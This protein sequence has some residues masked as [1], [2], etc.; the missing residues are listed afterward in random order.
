M[1]DFAKSVYYISNCLEAFK[2]TEGKVT[3]LIKFL[4][5]TSRLIARVKFLFTLL[6]LHT[7]MMLVSVSNGICQ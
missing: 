2:S 1:A 5:V 4:H 7:N 6:H 3:M